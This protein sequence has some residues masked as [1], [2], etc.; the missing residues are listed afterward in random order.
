M[1]ARGR[2]VGDRG[3]RRAMRYFGPIFLAV[4][5]GLIQFAVMQADHAAE[6]DYWRSYDRGAKAK[7]E[8]WDRYTRALTRPAVTP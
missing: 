8:F 2:R 4:L 5:A 7:H 1:A 6:R 3:P